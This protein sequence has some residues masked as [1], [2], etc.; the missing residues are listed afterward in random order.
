LGP[1]EFID[2]AVFYYRP[3]EA[4]IRSYCHQVRSHR[5]CYLPGYQS[6]YQ[7]KST[8]RKYEETQADSKHDGSLGVPSLV[9]NQILNHYLF[10]FSIS[11]ANTHE[12]VD[13]L[14]LETGKDQDEYVS[15]AKD[16]HDQ[17]QVHDVEKDIES[18]EEER[19]G[20]YVVSQYAHDNQV[21]AHEKLMYR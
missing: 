20:C 15:Q 2:L 9:C 3:K 21:Q 5:C 17:Q 14:L 4:E 1:E 18:F 7:S 11:F 13:E 10:K 16:H 6:G 19:L 12:H 8:T